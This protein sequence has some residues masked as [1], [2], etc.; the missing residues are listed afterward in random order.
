MIWYTK[1]K[2]R[3]ELKKQANMLRQGLDMLPLSVF[4]NLIIKADGTYMGPLE[5][6]NE[7]SAAADRM[8]RQ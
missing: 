5:A 4:K 8:E 3:R 2:A 6:M 7:I 1:W